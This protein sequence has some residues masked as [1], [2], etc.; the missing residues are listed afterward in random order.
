MRVQRDPD[1]FSVQQHRHVTDVFGDERLIHE[2]FPACFLD[3]CKLV[4]QVARVS[5]EV[6]ERSVLRGIAGVRSALQRATRTV[7]KLPKPILL[8]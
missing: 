5:G 3:A 2:D 1:A 6:D 4:V 7:W 8:G